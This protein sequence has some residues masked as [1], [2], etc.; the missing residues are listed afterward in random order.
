M[1]R[2]EYKIAL[3]FADAL[4]LRTRLRA[5]MQRDSH[6]GA[7]GTYRIRSFYFDDCRDTALA[8]KIAGVNTR[9]KFRLRCYNDDTSLIRLERKCKRN[10][11]CR[12]TAAALTPAQAR[13]LLDG[14]SD[15]MMQADDPFLRE[16][17]VLFRSLR[18]KTI[19]Q[20]TREAFVFSAGNVR[21]TIDSDIRT[22]IYG[23]DF[24]SPDLPLVPSSETP[25]LLEIKY[26]R[27]LPEIIRCLTQLDRAREG[28]FSKYT[29]ARRF[30]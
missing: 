4:L 19:V 5:V 12:K 8:E 6:A 10:G 23:G 9:Q 15:W 30:D 28:A 29:A 16:C 18:P 25:C 26:D 20:Y 11:L 21:V 27:Y 22:G 13:A 7:D 3:S 17:A 24:F 2:H 14:Q 1:D